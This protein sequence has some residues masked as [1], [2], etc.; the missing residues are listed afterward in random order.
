MQL[1]LNNTSF[2][3]TLYNDLKVLS[4]SEQIFSAM[5]EAMEAA[6]KH[7]HLETYILRSDEIGTRI[8]EIL[9]Q[10]ASEGVDIR[11]IYDGLGSGNL[12]EG[13]LQS[14]RDAGV[15]IRP[16]FPVR[17][18]FLHNRINYRNHRKILVV[19]DSTGFLGGVNIGDE[20][21]GRDPQVGNWRDTH[22]RINGNAV[23]YLHHIFLQD[24]FFITREPSHDE[25]PCPL[26]NKPGNKLVQIAASG[27]DTHWEAIMQIYYYAIATA[28]KSIFLTSPYFIP[29]ESILTSL[30]TAALGGVDVKILL[31]ANPDH[32]ILFYA[33]MSYLEE[34]LEAGVEIYLY[35]KGFIHAK[36]LTIDGIVS[37][38]GSA[39]MDQRSFKLNF[40]VNALIYDEEITQRLEADFWDDLQDS[41]PIV[42]ENFKERPLTRRIIESAT[43]LLSPLL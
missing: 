42:L 40:E 2:P 12:G 10:K 5:I 33:A 34:L 26:T 28:E 43:R 24:W 27:P 7:I 17:L 25:F 19:D 39:N 9:L 30:K 32:K 15:N 21:L 38:V 37:S 11:V 22:L 36:V 6:Q 29:N 20:Y 4:G 14:L 18:S 13:Y 35:K 31:P 3:V 8:I 41:E 23:C 1:I 16:F